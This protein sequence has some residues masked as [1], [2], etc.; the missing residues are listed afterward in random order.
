M[1]TCQTRNN[2]NNRT[3]KHNLKFTLLTRKFLKVIGFV[4]HLQNVMP[5]ENKD[6]PRMIKPASP[7]P[8]ILELIV[9]NTENWDH[10][11]SIILENHY[12][13]EF[14]KIQENL[15]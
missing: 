15:S 1:Q 8:E 12:K 2:R 7:T 6:D 10:A 14:N 4:H 9:G 5:K 3:Q 11:T 13:E